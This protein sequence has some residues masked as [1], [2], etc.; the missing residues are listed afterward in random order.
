MASSDHQGTPTSTRSSLSRL[1]SSSISPAAEDADSGVRHES[2]ISAK[3]DYIVTKTN[4]KRTQDALHDYSV[5]MRDY[6]SIVKPNGNSNDQRRMPS[7]AADSA[8][9]ST[10]TIS[11]QQQPGSSQ[12]RGR[13][14]G[15]KNST[16]AC[17]ICKGKK[18]RCDGTQPCARCTRLLLNCTYD[19]KYT[20]GVYVAPMRSMALQTDPL[21][22]SSQSRPLSSRVVTGIDTIDRALENVQGHMLG[23]M[24]SKREQ[25]SPA[26]TVPPD[27]YSPASLNTIS[28]G[29]STVNKFIEKKGDG[30]GPNDNITASIPIDDASNIVD[31]TGYRGGA[32]EQISAGHPAVPPHQRQF[33]FNELP[34]GV[35]DSKFLALPPKKVA[36]K[37]VDWYFDNA[38]PTYRILHRPLVEE[39]INMGFYSDSS[40]ENFLDVN[41]TPHMSPEHEASRRKLLGDPSISAVIFSVWAMGCQF[42]VDINDNDLD[43][44][45]MLQYRSQQFFLIAQ[46]ELER[47]SVVGDQLTALQAQVIMIEYLLTTSRVKA[48]WDLLLLV[49]NTANTLDLNRRETRYNRRQTRDRLRLELKKRTFWAIYIMETYMCTMLGKT[50]TWAEEDITVDWPAIARYELLQQITDVNG[51]AAADAIASFDYGD[52]KSLPSLM[53][54][55]VGQAKLS[56]IVRS[57]L[58]RLYPGHP[59]VNQ[60]SIIDELSEQVQQW[61]KELPSFLTEGSET[62]ALP[63]SRQADV[64]H[65]AR[66]HAL[67]LISRPS[68]NLFDG[69]AEASKLSSLSPVDIPPRRK[70]QQDYCLEAAM[71]VAQYRDFSGLTGSNWFVAYVAFCAITVMFVYLSYHPQAPQRHRVLQGARQLCDV[72]MML[73][74]ESDMAKRYVSA[75]K[76]LWQQVRNRLRK[77]MSDEARSNSQFERYGNSECAVSSSALQGATSRQ[78]N[79][80]NTSDMM[81]A[82]NYPNESGSS[83]ALQ[84][85]GPYSSFFPVLS[86]QEQQFSTFPTSGERMTGKQRQ[87]A[88]RKQITYEDND[89]TVNLTDDGFWAFESWDNGLMAKYAS[90][91]RGG[92]ITPLGSL[93]LISGA[94]S[95]GHFGAPG[96][97]GQSPAAPATANNATPGS[98]V[99]A[100]ELSKMLF[101]DLLE[102]LAQ[103]FQGFDSAAS[104]GFAGQ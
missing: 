48:A 67:I 66:E 51:D 31:N 82:T 58:R 85:S 13:K 45:R 56:R 60:E 54:S 83:R 30:T 87:S 7:N 26:D 20:R 93:G 55:L 38:A 69:M 95:A 91:S 71:R 17:D 15:R 92:T 50:L 86:D 16:R 25:N 97:V 79:D 23:A 5:D 3:S 37:L 59:I 74:R 40:S 64:V 2:G 10:V 41:V 46:L 90:T 44:R 49:K 34:I 98:D 43:H 89:F 14:R 12:R 21:P 62:L 8:S 53:Y 68:L 22:E 32:S 84:A 19:C 29:D 73:A 99:G 102:N 4:A 63:Y 75:L 104:A 27:T 6:D 42:P 18:I 70:A 94:A 103:S 72:E 39:W 1:S 52:K 65:L 76:E 36:A 28:S 47:T 100:D 24:W 57:A 81:H 61:Q 88:N 77:Q 9:A 80:T 11:P 33:W 96:T 35:I 78:G 101:G